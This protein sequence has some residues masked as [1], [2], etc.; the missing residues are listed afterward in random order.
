LEQALPSKCSLHDLLAPGRQSRE[1]QKATLGCRYLK[2]PLRGNDL[3]VAVNL[4]G[5][6]ASL[7]RLLNLHGRHGDTCFADAALMAGNTPIGELSVF[8]RAYL[9]HNLV[10]DLNAR[11]QRDE[12]IDDKI[13]E[14]LFGKLEENIL[15]GSGK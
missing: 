15:R 1:L 3:D 14:L 10:S 7:A 2:P 5:P 4:H 6:L 8:Q 11:V 9:V 12:V 13:V